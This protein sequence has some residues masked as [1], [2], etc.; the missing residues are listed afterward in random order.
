MPTEINKPLEVSAAKYGAFKGV[1][2]PSLLTILGVIM[3][4]RL[5]WVLGNVGLFQ[6]LII[7]CMSCSITFLT[8]LS[9]SA[10]ATN[11]K[12]GGGGAYYLISRSLGVETGAAIGLPLFLAQ[13]LA[14]SFYIAGFSESVVSLF[15]WLSFKLISIT[16]LLALTIL[17]YISSNIVLRIQFIILL[18]IVASLISFFLGGSVSPTLISDLPIP[19]KESFWP[20]FAVF[21]PAVTGIEAGLALSGELKKPEKALPI[22]TLGA[23][24]VST[25][26]Y[27]AIPIFLS[28]IIQ[29]EELLLTQLMIMKDVARMGEFII[30]GLWGATL[31]SALGAILGASRTLQ[32]LA[33]DRIVFGFLGKSYGKNEEPRLATLI[34]ATIALF[35]VM[36]GGLNFIA[37][38]LTMF[39]LT[40]YGLLNMASGFESLIGNPSW[41]PTIRIPWYISF[42]GFLACLFVMLMIDPGATIS[43]FL[44]SISVYVL[45]KRRGLKAHWGDI[46][47]G[48]LNLVSQLALYKITQIKPD[49]KTWRPNILVLSGSPTNRWHLIALA[50]AISHGK[51]FLTVAS[52]VSEHVK[53]GDRELQM[54]KTIKDYLDKRNVPAMV[55]I[56]SS[57]NVWEG[58]QTLVRAYGFGPL[59]PNTVLLGYT[60]KQENI[61]DFSKL[62]QTTYDQ[63]KNTIMVWE[64]EATPEVN[65][66]GEIDL[67]L[68]NVQQNSGLMLALAYM[69]KTSP[70]WEKSNLNLKTIVDTEAEIEGAEK[71]LD[72]FVEGCRLKATTT[73]VLRN[74]LKS[75]EVIEKNSRKAD[76]VFIGCKSPIDLA[77]PDDYS[78]YFVKLRKNILHMPPTVVVLAAEEIDFKSIFT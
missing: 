61:P 18:L 28:R 54:E 77:S 35:G 62:V 34:T 73:A 58:A 15:P 41:R 31:S 71:K 50:D 11:M 10:L 68:G 43:S 45:I 22:G 44:V 53:T 60:D 26:V 33:K 2:T 16:C 76:I 74:D 52:I 38:V 5:G 1:F 56:Y 12:V 8:A 55:K 64:G 72:I 47:Y 42:L 40:S 36:A 66:K 17:A 27:I 19:E 20:V 9:I 3:Y 46:R 65:Y 21:F 39:F 32:A 59:E 25:I 51:G 78:D 24:V 57:A 49:G 6:T 7:V 4:M 37:P 48:V 63:G 69:L 30:A 75:F 67:W 70:E 29:Q 14:V 13:A 23:V